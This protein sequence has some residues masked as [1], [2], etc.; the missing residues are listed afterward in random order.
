[1]VKPVKCTL[2]FIFSIITLGVK[3]QSAKIDS[4]K[5]AFGKELQDT[6]KINILLAIANAYSYEQTDSA[7]LYCKKAKNLAEKIED[8]K[9]IIKVDFEMGWNYTSL[10]K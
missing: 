3:S 5:R 9:R 2:L 8:E 7:I 6:T 10:G 1:M 4:I